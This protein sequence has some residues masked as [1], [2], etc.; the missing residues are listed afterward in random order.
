MP[1]ASPSKYDFSSIFKI[2]ILY[3]V[4][5]EGLESEAQ[6]Y[7]KRHYYEQHHREG[8]QVLPFK[9]ENLVDTQAGERPTLPHE[10]EHY[11]ERFA[12][13]PHATGYQGHDIVEAFE[14][15]EVYRSPAAEE[16]CR[17]HTGADEEVEVFGQVVIAE[18]HTRILCVV[19]G[20]QFA[21]ALRQVKRATVTLGVAGNEVNDESQH[22]GH[23][24]AQDIPTI[25]SLLLADFRNFLMH[26]GTESESGV[27]EVLDL[28]LPVCF[29][30][31]IRKV[32][33]L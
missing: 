1:H 16:D 21:L 31:F 28:W 11:E 13:E 4:C 30:S 25:V 10:Q 3:I 14:A 17:C 2:S 5:G 7:A 18:V 29:E 23:V 33:S 32:R 19:A 27:M 26:A 15:G 12:K 22:C 9:R 20:S 6:R 8:Q 24:A